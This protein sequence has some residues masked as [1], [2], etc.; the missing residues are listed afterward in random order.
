MLSLAKRHGHF[1][2]VEVY[3]LLLK[4]S[5]LRINYTLE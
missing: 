5:I 2:I 1:D 3:E 4:T